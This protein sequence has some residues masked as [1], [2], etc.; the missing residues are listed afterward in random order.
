MNR[1]SPFYFSEKLPDSV[2]VCN[3]TTIIDVTQ[4][5]GIDR[6]EVLFSI[7]ENR[8][9]F[10]ITDLVF[11]KKHNDEGYFFNG[12]TD[13]AGNHL[14]YPDAASVMRDLRLMVDETKVELSV[15]GITDCHTDKDENNFFIQ[16]ENGNLRWAKQSLQS[17]MDKD[18]IPH[19]GNC[20]G[21]PYLSYRSDKPE[22]SNG[23]CAY[24]DYGD[25][26]NKLGFSLLWDGLKECQINLD[27]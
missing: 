11:L 18:F 9:G 19:G 12:L 27:E 2:P 1:Q 15:F 8:H 5:S 22:E 13:N 7:N 16:I 3:L 21:C 23:Y 24:L 10:F 4:D 25:W 17:L 20:Y 6:L 14:L 26:M